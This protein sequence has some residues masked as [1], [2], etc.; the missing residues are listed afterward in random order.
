M[1]A[2]VTSI[3]EPTTE[4]CCWSLTRLGFDVV[5]VESVATSLWSK[6]YQIFHYAQGDFLRVDAD[7]IVNKNV[8]ELVEQKD[9]IWYQAL[10]YDWHKQDIAHGGVQF[11]RQEAIEP[12]KRAIYEAQQKERPESYLYRIE[13][14]HNPRVCG[15]FEKVC[16]LNGYG[17]ED[18]QRIK[19]TKERRGQMDNYDFE[20]SEKISK[21][22]KED[23][24]SE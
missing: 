16:G 9:L 8:L 1:K 5:L 18:I 17:Q 6:L 10:T 2:Y 13:A 4:L 12:V 23:V 20:L 19:Q 22:G 21:L 11:I 24:E 3:G 7:V 14:F 15:T